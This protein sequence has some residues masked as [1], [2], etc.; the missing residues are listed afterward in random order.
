MEEKKVLEVAE[1]LLEKVTGGVLDDAG[2]S[3]LDNYIRNYKSS[4]GS[5]PGSLISKI[6]SM[7]PTFF[8]REIGE[9][10]TMED[11]SAYILENWDKIN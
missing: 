5:T 3:A 11:V 7:P 10:A 2:K 1:D 8:A 4:E 9:D 6:Q